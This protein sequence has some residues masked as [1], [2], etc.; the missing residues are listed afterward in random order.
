MNLN[1]I[2]ERLLAIRK[3]TSRTDTSRLSEER[4][5][6]RLTEARRQLNDL[7]QRVNYESG[8][9]AA[10]YISEICSDWNTSDLRQESSA[11]SSSDVP[12]FH[13]QAS[14]YSGYYNNDLYQKILPLCRL[15]RLHERNGIPESHALKL[16]L[17]F[18][19]EQSVYHY[20][21]NFPKGNRVDNLVHDACLFDLPDFE[22]CD[23]SQWKKIA[24]K[25]DNMLNPRFRKLLPHA[26]A[27]ERLN[28][29]IVPVSVTSGKVKA[30]E[31]KAKEKELA[32]AMKQH[33]VLVE[34]PLDDPTE[35]GRAERQKNLSLWSQEKSRISMELTDLAA[36][37]PLAD[38]SCLVLQAFY[39]RYKATS[40]PEHRILIQYGLGEKSIATFYSLQR[41]NDDEAIPAITIKGSDLGY[42]HCYLT[43]L[44][45]QSDKGATL[46]A[47]LGKITRCCQYLG[48]AG[49]ACARHG[50]ESPNGGFYVLF[51]GDENNPSLNDKILAQGWVWRSLEGNLCIDSVETAYSNI[52]QQIVDMYRYLG[53]LLCEYKDIQRV[54]I[55]AFSGVAHHVGHDDYSVGALT[56]LDHPGYNDSMAQLFLADAFMPYIFYGRKDA[57]RLGELIKEKTRTLFAN[58]FAQPDALK[59]NEQ[60]KQ[61]TA[62]LIASN[63]NKVDSPIVKVILDAAGE[64]VDEFLEL[65]EVNRRYGRILE[66]PYTQSH[67]EDLCLM[68][69]Q[70]ACINVTNES[71]KTALH[72]AAGNFESLRVLLELIP[73]KQKLD[74]VKAVDGF[75]KTLLHYTVK[76]SEFLRTILQIY[77]ESQ[78]LDAVKMIDYS[79]KNLLHLGAMNIDSLMI[80][81]ELYPEAQRLGAAK[82]KDENR[83]SVLHWAAS[84]PESLRIILSLYP[85]AQRVDAVKEEDRFHLTPLYYASKNSKS[86]II[87]LESLLEDDRIEVIHELKRHDEQ[88]L[89]DLVKIPE[90]LR[91]MLDLLPQE[92]KLLAMKPVGRH[93]RRV[94]RCASSNPECL[95]VLHQLVPELF[96]AGEVRKSSSSRAASSSESRNAFFG[97]GLSTEDERVTADTKKDT[98][99]DLKGTG[100]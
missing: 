9:V 12:D 36:G 61:A 49:D 21:I 37:I 19:D 48:G 30:D 93:G 57:D 41:N 80:L 16:S 24:A 33:R 88:L 87:L 40:N 25:R 74:V 90:T 56:A 65:V 86:F 4:Q 39:E 73:E 76:N 51:Q 47:C 44:D 52:T 82:M 99:L 97:S 26:G 94:L 10:G 64:R 78:R 13:P 28:R 85:E 45:I 46:A 59:Q 68:L 29:S 1:E 3:L 7:L 27:I 95:N 66:F 60:L 75:G 6:A 84:H 5:A 53:M 77:P 89:H 2:L 58:F 38:A 55:G 22:L 8:S 100:I 63:H 14:Q 92:H 11:S 71:R 69:H 81:L 79:G 31:I 96:R 15:A 43:K 32:N 18:E 70:G 42:D 34:R 83:K 67:F 17:I 62:Y 91:V 54:H 20:L 50:I 98:G 72:W 23:F 35:A